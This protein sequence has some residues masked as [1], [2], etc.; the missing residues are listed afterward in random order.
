MVVVET[1]KSSRFTVMGM[2]DYLEAGDCHLK[3]DREIL[4]KEA[5]E[6]QRTLNAT[7]SMIAKMFKVGEGTDQRE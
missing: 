7:G 3:Y 6:V 5:N 4:E 2:E 1:D